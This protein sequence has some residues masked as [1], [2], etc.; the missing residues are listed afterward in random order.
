L[1][2]TLFLTLAVVLVTVLALAGCGK[3]DDG[4]AAAVSPLTTLQ[5]D[6]ATLKAKVVVIEGQLINVPVTVPNLTALQTDLGNVKVEVATL[7]GQISTLQQPS[8][9]WASVQSVNNLSDTV[10]TLSSTVNSFDA[11]LDAFEIENPDTSGIQVNAAAIEQ[12]LLEIVGIEEEIAGLNTLISGF[13]SDLADLEDEVANIELPNLQNGSPYISI[14][15]FRSGSLELAA[16]GVGDYVAI[17][18][19]YGTDLMIGEADILDAEI[20]KEL[21]FGQEIKEGYPY[22]G[23]ALNP[24][25]VITSIENTHTHTVDL[26]GIEVF[27]PFYYLDDVGTTLIIFVVPEWG[28]WSDGE[29]FEID[30]GTMIV[31]YA[32]V[33]V[34]YSR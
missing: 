23:F 24:D 10:N 20:E 25:S 14:E 1:K 34:G 9:S 22:D 27:V 18:T 30:F 15:K 11:R 33:E 5:N 6:V 28:D 26:G 12:I 3:A 29:L 13:A 17:I 31:D 4:G 7:K 8:G 32:T 2:K 16:H 21:L 19:L